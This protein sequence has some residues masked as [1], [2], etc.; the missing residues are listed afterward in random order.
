M[1]QAA[2]TIYGLLISRLFT[3]SAT[4]HWITTTVPMLKKPLGPRLAAM[5]SRMEE[6]RLADATTNLLVEFQ[7]AQCFFVLAIQISL[8]YA[9][10]QGVSFTDSSS[11]SGLIANEQWI[12]QSALFVLFP[13]VLTQ[14]NLRRIRRDSIYLYLLCTVAI[15]LGGEVVNKSPLSY[16]QDGFWSMFMGHFPVEE[17]GGNTSLRAYCSR[18]GELY[19]H[20]GPNI[21]PYLFVLFGTL[22]FERLFI[23]LRY[24][25]WYKRLHSSLSRVQARAVALTGNTVS[26]ALTFL[27]AASEITLVIF[28]GESFYTI[29]D[30]TTGDW[31]IGQ[32]IAAL[33]WAPVLVKYLYQ[34]IRKLCSVSPGLSYLLQIL[35]SNMKVTDLPINSR[36]FQRH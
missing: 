1:M 14:I 17:C 18:H 13:I 32:L 34:I 12:R 7:E 15:V 6:S 19:V 28:I 2:V 35:C 20:A 29:L 3:V 31:N 10:L 23:I 8:L 33:I 5:L 26:F 22:F 36:R 16:S 11:V 21:L 9:T 4:I 24:S 25:G 30:Q 27:Y